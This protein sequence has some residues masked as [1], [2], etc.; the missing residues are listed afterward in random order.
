M[1]S[2]SNDYIVTDKYVIYNYD[3][4]YDEIDD[5][6]EDEEVEVEEDEIVTATSESGEEITE[7][8]GETINANSSEVLGDTEEESDE[9]IQSNNDEV[10]DSY[11][12][13]EVEDGYNVTKI[14]SINGSNPKEVIEHELLNNFDIDGNYIYYTNENHDLYKTKINSGKSELVYN[15]RDVYHLNIKNNYAYF[16]SHTDNNEVALYRVDL[17]HT[18]KGA[19]EVK[20]LNTTTPCLNIIDNCIY[21]T[22]N[23]DTFSFSI[24]LLNINDFT[25]VVNL[26]NY[27]YENFYSTNNGEKSSLDID[28]E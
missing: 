23:S 24:N 16:Y 10:V 11:N 28:A 17:N 2:E 9:V 27:N 1:N 13:D 3:S 21:Y 6:D 20:K 18:D 8:Q 19:Q 26:Y 15:G 12:Y 7:V 14:M 4:N 5:E 25:N 22:D